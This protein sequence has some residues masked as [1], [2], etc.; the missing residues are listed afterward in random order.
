MPVPVSVVKVVYLRMTVTARYKHAVCR[1]GIYHMRQSLVD[2]AAKIVASH[3]SV[4]HSMPVNPICSTYL[5]LH[6]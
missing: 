4:F 2:P 3:P 6:P 5:S 1:D